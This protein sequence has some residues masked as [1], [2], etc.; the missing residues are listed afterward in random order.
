[1]LTHLAV[2][3]KSRRT[4]AAC[5][6]NAASGSDYTGFSAY[7]TCN[8]CRGTKLY[9]EAASGVTPVHTAAIHYLE[10]ALRD[11]GYSILEAERETKK[12]MTPVSGSA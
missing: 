9:L 2:T 4:F 5:G 1:M 11:N 7:V 10:A 3:N 12:L 8:K 6:V